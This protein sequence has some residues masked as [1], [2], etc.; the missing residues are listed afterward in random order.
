ML[1]ADLEEIFDKGR[2]QFVK[3]QVLVEQVLERDKYLDLDYTMTPE[4]IQDFRGFMAR[5]PTKNKKLPPGEYEAFLRA[6]S[7]PPERC[8]PRMSPPLFP[9]SETIGLGGKKKGI[10]QETL[11][12]LLNAV[13]TEP[14]PVDDGEFS[15]DGIAQESMKLLCG[16]MDHVLEALS[17]TPSPPQPPPL[18]WSSS[19]AAQPSSPLPQT[20]R[21]LHPSEMAFFASSPP[22]AYGRTEKIAKFDEVLFPKDQ[23]RG[24]KLLPKDQP[25]FSEFISG[26]HHPVP[27]RPAQHLAP[28]I[29]TILVPTSPSESAQSDSVLAQA[30]EE[31]DELADDF[32]AG[33]PS[34]IGSKNPS[35]R[36]S[37][38]VGRKGSKLSRMA[39]T[40]SIHTAS[41]ASI[42][43]D[44]D[45]LADDDT[46]VSCVVERLTK[47]VGDPLEYIMKE[48]IE[49]KEVF[50]LDVPDLPPPNVHERDGPPLPT[51]L[52]EAS[53][54]IGLGRARGIPSL[55][56]ELEWRIT[57]PGD[58]LPTHE[59]AAQA[60]SPY[61]A[62]TKAK[63]KENI[64]S[65]LAR[66]N[67]EPG[68]L[69]VFR[70]EEPNVQVGGA[71][72]RENLKL[73]LTKGER[74]RLYGREEEEEEGYFEDYVPVDTYEPIRDPDEEV[75]LA[76]QMT[77]V[78][79][80][81]GSEQQQES[82]DMEVEPVEYGNFERQGS[83]GLDECIDA[84]G[85]QTY[86]FELQQDDPGIQQEYEQPLNDEQHNDEEFSSLV[87]QIQEREPVDDWFQILEQTQAHAQLE[88]SPLPT[89]TPPTPISE[90]LQWK[91]VQPC[92][93]A[94]HKLASFIHARTGKPQ[95]VDRSPTPNPAPTPTPA[96][97]PERIGPRAIPTEVESMLTIAP[98]DPR[99]NP[100][101]QPYRII[102]GMQI[103]QH[104]ALV[105]R[106][107][108]SSINL[109]LIERAGEIAEG[110]FSWQ[111]AGP[112]LHGASFA[113][114]P[115]TAVVLVPLAHLPCPDA[116][117]ALSR[118]LQSLLNRYDSVNLVLEAYSKAKSDLDPFTPPARK[119]LGSVRRAV[120]LIN[121][122]LGRTGVKVGIARSADECARLVRTVVDCAAREWTGAWEVWGAR[123]WVGDDELPEET[124]LSSVPSM[125]VFASVTLLAQVTIDELLDL[126]REE[127]SALFGPSVGAAR[128]DALN[129]AIE[130]GR[131]RVE[132]VRG[133]GTHGRS[134]QQDSLSK[135]QNCTE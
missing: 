30:D 26:L 20:P 113:I 77:F 120:A 106:L 65:L 54:Q 2:I 86:D 58:R 107:E 100:E 41:Q 131:E 81:F 46:L 111:D 71:W 130:K 85:Q 88:D 94:K 34:R 104:R 108:H 127:R 53:S 98:F 69:G 134:P 12:G 67:R 123:E 1:P 62:E 49:E 56:L 132:Q 27:L 105:Q 99:D 89:P 102:A 73:I 91:D 35:R 109:Q 129:E 32:S 47:G 22:D 72:V 28:P 82:W 63:A 39:S 45:E 23:M 79:L 112:P 4:M 128:I 24:R 55:Q 52:A 19:D 37:K 13:G 125:N 92:H 117:P 44:I 48:K 96:P 15:L 95:P 59:Q 60:D 18:Q 7:P 83:D 17:P 124:E 5:L 126:G 33:I 103:I 50:M 3:E 74:E 68:A 76:T 121:G 38:N 78:P 57:M 64:R 14:A 80:S 70:E 25:K 51:N 61:E 43:S 36:A 21:R 9:R 122:S 116:V 90:P 101:P 97:E 10:A 87:D 8:L 75:P 11:S 6:E 42:P 133:A 16:N 29:A 115:R 114:D 119:A 118:L 66:L 31:M 110:L 40:I 84:S 135:D 93:S